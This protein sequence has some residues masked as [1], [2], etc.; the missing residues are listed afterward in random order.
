MT[1][2]QS[3]N[4]NEEEPN[5]FTIENILNKDENNLPFGYYNPETDGKV[6]WICNTGSDGKIVGVFSCDC[7]DHTE[8]DV[9]HLENMEQALFF[10]DELVKHGWRK[11]VP[12]KMNF[13]MSKNDG[14]PS[15]EMNRKQKRALEK[16]IKSISKSMQSGE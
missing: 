4:E 8:K 16:K 15:K 11:L 5:G 1:E 7:I 6:T 2:K 13:T 12:P 14:T 3:F 10:R 9:R